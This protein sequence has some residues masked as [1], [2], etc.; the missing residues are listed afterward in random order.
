MPCIPIKDGVLRVG[1]PSHDFDGILFEVHSRHGPTPLR[2]SD[3]AVRQTTPSGFWKMW[4]RFEQ[5]SK[6]EREQWLAKTKRSQRMND[7]TKQE[8][9]PH[10]LIDDESDEPWQ[11]IGSAKNLALSA[12]NIKASVQV[13]LDQ[14]LAGESGDQTTLTIRRTDMTED[15]FDALPEL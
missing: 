4:E 9:T 2:R 15:E 14:L 13:A 8:S 7:D 1:V 6:A 3:H 5:L 11:L 10:F 12:E